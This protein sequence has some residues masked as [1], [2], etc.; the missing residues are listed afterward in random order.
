[1]QDMPTGAYKRFQKM[2]ERDQERLLRKVV[3]GTFFGFVECDIKVPEADRDYW[4]E[5]PN[6]K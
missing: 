4:A 1:M 3:K 5:M 6:L 2:Q